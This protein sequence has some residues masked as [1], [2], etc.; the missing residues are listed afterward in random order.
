[1]PGNGDVRAHLN[2]FFDI[3]DKINEIGVE[4]DADLL[5]TLLLLSLPNEFENFR[6]AIEARDML[7]TLDT[8]RIKITEEADARKGIAGSHSSNAMYAKKQYKK[9]QKRSEDVNENSSSSTFKY[10]CHKCKIVGHKAS[11][12]KAQKKDSQNATDTTM[13][14]SEAFLTGMTEMSKWCLDSEATS[15]FCYKANLA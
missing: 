2:Q 4:I 7:P 14:T 11:D 8:L 9:Q 1:M 5:S 15:H 3:V 13:L 6:C 12:C 10:K